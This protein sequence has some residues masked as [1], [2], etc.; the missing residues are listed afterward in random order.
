MNFIN[1]EIVKHCLANTPQITFEITEKC[2]LSCSYCGYGKIYNN[3]DPRSNRS[4]RPKDAYAFLMYIKGL[5]ETGYSTTGDDII[6]ISFYGGEPLLNMDFIQSCVSYIEEHLCGFNKTFVFS[7]TTNALLLPKYMDYFAE[8]NFRLLI[9]LDGDEQGSSYRQYHTEKPAFKDIVAAVNKLREKYPIYYKDC[10]NF[11][12]VLSNRSTVESINRFI[13]LEFGKVPSISEI[14]DTGI[15][16]DYKDEFMAMYRNKEDSMVRVNK[17]DNFLNDPRFDGIARYMQ[18][19]SPFFYLGYEELFFGKKQRKFIPTGTCLPFGK[20]V[21][22]TV[23]G[24]IM[25]CERIGYQYYLGMVKD[26][27]INIDFEAIAQKYNEYY[28]R[29]EK[30]C[31]CCADRRT[32]LCCM[33]NNGI[34][35]NRKDKCSYFVTQTEADVRSRDVEDF[36]MIYHEAYSYIQKYYETI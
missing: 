14:N 4:L 25:P 9:S 5:W 12:S 16:P 29:A 11:N 17:M 22:I 20:K 27:E 18:M 34:V 8:K 35:D 32:C 24:K 28:T 3:K 33:F 15:N 31:Q 13:L 2:N 7:L 10:V 19:H 1:A 36:F 21:F 23:G 6:Y 30:N 26:G